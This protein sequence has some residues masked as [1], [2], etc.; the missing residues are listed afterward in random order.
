MS[1]L[2]LQCQ[3]SVLLCVKGR[4]GLVHVAH[5]FRDDCVVSCVKPAPYRDRPSGLLLLLLLLLAARGRYPACVFRE[6]GRVLLFLSFADTNQ[7]SWAFPFWEIG[8]CTA[9]LH[10][11]E[12]G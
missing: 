10:Q 5:V 11:R 8:D 2:G 6:D 12:L 3:G 1:H 7:C 9:F 4:T